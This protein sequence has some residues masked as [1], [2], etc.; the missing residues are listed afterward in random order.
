VDDLLNKKIILVGL[1]VLIMASLASAVTVERVI[2][3]TVEA[4]NTIDIQINI[5]LDGDSPSSLIVTEEIPTGWEVVNSNPKATAFDNHIKWLLYGN[6]LKQ[7]TSVKYTLKAPANFSEVQT[8]KGQ[9][10]TL[11]DTGSVTGATAIA[12]TPAGAG[13]PP[14]TPPQTPSDNTLLIAGVVVLIIIVVAVYFV[15]KKK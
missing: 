6:K 14:I 10:K 7:S 11:T 8:L 5:D 1:A 13:G 15:K 12:E 4:G 9:W 3:E 2:D